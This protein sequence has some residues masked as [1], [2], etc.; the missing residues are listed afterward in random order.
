MYLVW[1]YNHID[2]LRP[3]QAAMVASI[4]ASAGQGQPPWLCVN[5]LR[6][7][8]SLRDPCQVHSTITSPSV[9]VAKLYSQNSVQLIVVPSGWSLTVY[10]QQ[11]NV[12]K[13]VN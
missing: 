7:W 1:Y 3:D 5:I 10:L 2:Q 11:T 8:V 9:V 6:G 4:P 12:K 13:I